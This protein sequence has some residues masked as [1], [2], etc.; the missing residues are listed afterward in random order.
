MWDWKKEGSANR[1]YPDEASA[2]GS[3]SDRASRAPGESCLGFT[4]MMVHGRNPE[5]GVKD[6]PVTDT[7]V[8]DADEIRSVEARNIVFAAASRAGFSREGNF[9]RHF[10]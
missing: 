5:A 4:Q 9:R 10:R 6:A 8:S 3:D 2:Q 7:P 1:D